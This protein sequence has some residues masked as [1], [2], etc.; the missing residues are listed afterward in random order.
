MVTTFVNPSRFVVKLAWDVMDDV[1][2]QVITRW[3]LETATELLLANMSDAGYI[4][5]SD[6]DSGIGK[7]TNTS[8]SS[9]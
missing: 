4:S 1:M 5:D 6:N 3:T 8:S 9:L 2:R 7:Y